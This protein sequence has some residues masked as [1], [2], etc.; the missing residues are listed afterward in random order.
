MN[1]KNGD[2]FTS[3]RDLMPWLLVW[4]FIIV[5][6]LL[7]LFQRVYAGL[8]ILVLLIIFVGWIFFATGYR[9]TQK[10]LI[11]SNGPFRYKIVLSDIKA[12]KKTTSQK[13][14]PASSMDRLEISYGYAKNIIIS[15]ADQASFIRAIKKSAPQIAL[16][17]GLKI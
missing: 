8:I 16:D 17:P 11:V 5:I 13:A 3:K 9:I 1:D 14:S 6:A 2:Y 4:G 15:P 12:I 10:E 7:M